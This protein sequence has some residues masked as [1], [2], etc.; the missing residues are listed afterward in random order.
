MTK[1]PPARFLFPINLS[2][3]SQ[4]RH[5]REKWPNRPRSDFCFRSISQIL[6]H[7]DTVAK[8]DEITPGRFLLPINQPNFSP[9]RHHREK[10]RN[11]PPA[12]FL[13]PINQSNFSPFQRSLDKWWNC[14]RRD[15][16][17]GSISQILAHSDTVAKNDKIAPAR[18]LFPINQSNFSP[19][20]HS[21]EK[22]RNCPRR[23]ICFR[24]ISQILANSDTVAKND[25]I[26][27]GSIFVSD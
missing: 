19:F 24:S 11:C 13:F 14:P 3:F 21:L 1:Y 26:P 15:F 12:R 10:C 23:D 22:W 18:F 9:F 2:N 5:R 8:N 25:E 6:A 7:S 20:R 27:P 17:F 16:C 4:F